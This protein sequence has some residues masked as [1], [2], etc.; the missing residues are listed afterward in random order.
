MIKHFVSTIAAFLLLAVSPQASHGQ[1]IPK[2][3]RAPSAEK[4]DA[5]AKLEE[6]ASQPK[7]TVAPEEKP[8]FTSSLLLVKA[9]W[10]QVPAAKTIDKEL[11]EL[12]KD[13]AVPAEQ[14]EKLPA[15]GTEVLF[16][17]E[18]IGFYTSEHYAQFHAW[19]TANQLIQQTIP[20]TVSKQ[21]TTSEAAYPG[22]ELVAGQ[23][24]APTFES[25]FRQPLDFLGLPAHP[26]AESSTFV[27]RQP[28]LTW[29]VTLNKRERT[30]ALRRELVILEQARGQAEARVSTSLS[31]SSCNFQYSGPGVVITN[32]FLVSREA[33][34]RDAARAKGFV[35]LLVFDTDLRKMDADVTR[36]Q[37]HLPD[38]VDTVRE[39]SGILVWHVPSQASSNSTT[40]T[41]SAAQPELSVLSLQ[42]SRASTTAELLRQIF[43]GQSTT[44]SADQRANTIVVRAPREILDQITALVLRLDEPSDLKEASGETKTTSGSADTGGIVSQQ[45]QGATAPALEAIAGLRR[46]YDLMEQR[47]AATAQQLQQLRTNGKPQSRESTKLEQQLRKEVSDAFAARQEL[48]QAEVASLQQRVSQLQQTMSAR[49]RIQDQIIDRRVQDLLNPN[50]RWDSEKGQS[51]TRSGDSTTTSNPTVTGNT[52]T[53]E[54]PAPKVSNNP[55]RLPGNNIPLSDAVRAFNL[56]YAMHPIGKNQPALTDDEVVATI[57]HTLSSG[58]YL[59]TVDVHVLETIAEERALPLDGKIEALTEFEQPDGSKLTK[60]TIFLSLPGG[61]RAVFVPLIREQ[62]VR[63]EPAA[64]TAKGQPTAD[65]ADPKATPL[66]AAIHGFNEKHAGD[67]IGKDQP[68][69]TEDEVIAAIRWWKTKRAEAD[70]TNE[71]FQAFQEIANTRML[72]DKVEFEVLTGF[73]PNDQFRFDAWSVRIVMPRL[74]KAGW[75]YGFTVRD[76]WINSERLAARQISWGAPA[77]N[78]FQVGIVVKPHGEQYAAGQQIVPSFAFRN[79]GKQTLDVAFPNLMT[80]G[81]YNGLRVVD[82]AG[83]FIEI[84]QGP[85]PGSPVGWLQMELGPGREHLISGMPIALGD[86]SRDSGIETVIKAKPG[87]SCR[88]RFTVPNFSER[89]SK[90]IETGEVRFTMAPKD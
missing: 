54:S 24:A 76:R 88:L 14:M 12:L 87:Q 85:G 44:I 82:S 86:V 51:A 2:G 49:S 69:L 34:F 66:A 27:T 62:L 28:A 84:D 46:E 35:V 39:V 26:L 64:G 77:S 61:D 74:S 8:P 1:G 9:D 70:L 36:P 3:S 55:T 56:K 47:A 57:R 60:W 71:E 58:K 18:L 30:L 17:P 67:K 21:L 7:A 72:P 31:S 45:K 29:D 90:P 15:T 40:P 79:T 73:Q 4:S 38:K 53:G 16:A 83:I 43:E 25:H 48:H 65:V 59:A 6:E 42:N 20:F 10:S 11:R 81:Y 68:P 50:L 32:A 78:G 33:P 22:G 13:V 80:Q 75:T 41:S 19:L 52:L 5:P 23:Y 37:L 89:D 63:W